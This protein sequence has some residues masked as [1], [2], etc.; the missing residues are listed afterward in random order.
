MKKGTI[1]IY[2][3]D[4]ASES[5]ECL[6]VGCGYPVERIQDE[7]CLLERLRQ[8]DTGLLLFDFETRE[9]S[10][11][12]GLALLSGLR[13]VSEKPIVA[14][15][16][17]T[18]EMLRILALNAGA[19]D[20]L[21]HQDSA[22]ECFARIQAKIRC[23]ERWA[24]RED[25][26]VTLR[27]QDLE[28]D[29]NA[30]NVLVK[31]RPVRLTPIEYKILYLLITKQGCVLS[32]KEIYRSIWNMDPLGADNTIAVHIRHIREKIEE[33]PK[34]PRYLQVVWGQGYKVG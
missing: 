32:N 28:L 10:E 2:G 3:K 17:R 21:D 30:K 22:M 26:N 25:K 20:V 16:D 13:R 33:N 12:A 1:L 27:V 4:G 24:S 15:A 31:G 9:V 14:L 29:D 7:E 5:L 34:E 11:T 19:D 23:Y 18:H 8:E 6:C